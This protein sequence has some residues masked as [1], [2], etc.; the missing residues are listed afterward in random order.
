MKVA[1]DDEPYP[2][3]EKADEFARRLSSLGRDL[4][5]RVIG[6]P[7]LVVLEQDDYKFDYAVDAGSHLL[8]GNS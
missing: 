4:G 5:V 2:E 1:P 8:F 7:V 6:N 3:A